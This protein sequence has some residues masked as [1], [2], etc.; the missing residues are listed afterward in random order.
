M[1]KLAGKKASR[2]QEMV[3][4]QGKEQKSALLLFLPAQESDVQTPRSSQGAR[5]GIKGLGQ[6]E[7]FFCS[8][9]AGRCGLIKIREEPGMS[10]TY[11]VCTCTI[12]GEQLQ[13]VPS[14]HLPSLNILITI[15][16]SELPIFPPLHP[17]H[18][19]SSSSQNS[20]C[21]FAP[22]GEIHHSRH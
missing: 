3:K 2:G 1:A 19:R 9:V 5:F 8:K 11:T 13:R 14:K 6:E 10:P 16:P 15:I 4:R 17:F 7:T 18:P 12:H 22:Q 21:T 20:C